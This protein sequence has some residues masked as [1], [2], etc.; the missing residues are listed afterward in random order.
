VNLE[1]LT[2]AYKLSRLSVSPKQLLLDPRNP[3]LITESS[4]DRRYKPAEIRSPETQRYVLD[5]VC[6]KEHDVKRLI[7]RIKDMGF[8]GGLHEMIVKD[9]GRGGPYLV[10]EGNRRTAALQH[11]LENSNGLHPDVR[12]S[13]EHIEVKLFTYLSNADYDEQTVIDVLLGSIHIDGP[14]EWGALERAHYVH[15]SYLRVF[16]EKRSFRYDRDTAREVGSTFKLSG[17]A[18]QK[19]LIICRVYEQLCRAQVGVEP[20]HYT[21]IDLAAKTRSVA[22]P[23]FKLDRDTCELSQDGIERFTELV[24]KQGA[25]VHNPKLFDAFVKVYTDGTPLELQEVVA[26]DKPL[27]A[28]CNAIEQRRARH[29]F[30]DNLEIVKD[31]ISSL[32]VDDYRGTEGE[33][34]IIRRIQELVEK[35]LVPLLR[36]GSS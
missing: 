35:R 10:I 25:P 20:K 29:E 33:K 1:S 5:L 32:Y 8:I 13:I 27:D 34:A 30:R 7:S 6:R 4:Q 14:K 19:N 2:G 31:N 9:L 23:Y 18:V 26:G 17:K 12:K 24:L 22:E 21:L 15:R 28:A 16:G 3:R 11:L 36:V